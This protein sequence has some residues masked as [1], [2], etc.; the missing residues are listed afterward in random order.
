MGF[1]V[2]TV[3]GEPQG[4]QTVGLRVGV[5]TSGSESCRHCLQVDLKNAV[6][7]TYN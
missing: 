1:G 6:R 7:K 5:A 2:M 3:A 4:K